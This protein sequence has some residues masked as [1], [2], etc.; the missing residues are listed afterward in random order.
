MLGIAVYGI[1]CAVLFQ[2][3]SEFDVSADQLQYISKTAQ[4]KP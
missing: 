1:A 4:V 3:L 2:P